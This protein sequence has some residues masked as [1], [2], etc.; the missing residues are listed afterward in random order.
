[1]AMIRFAH[2]PGQ[3]QPGRRGAGFPAVPVPVLCLALLAP[4]HARPAT[5]EDFLR[6]PLY[7]DITL[8]PSG[9]YL[10]VTHRQEDAQALSTFRLPGLKPVSSTR[11]HKDEGLA[12]VIWASEKR[13]LLQPTRRWQRRGRVQVRTGE[14][15][16]IDVN[17]RNLTL[18]WSYRVSPYRETGPA[19]R[20]RSRTT[21]PSTWVRILD[22]L[23]RDPRR[24][25][26]QT[27]GYGPEGIL[28]QALRMDIH[29]GATR[30]LHRSPVRN[31]RFVVDI[32]HRIGLVAGEDLSGEYQVW[33]RE[34]DGP[35]RLVHRSPQMEGG[36]TPLMAWKRPG[37]YLFSDT[38]SHPTSALLAWN[39]VSGERQEIFRHPQVSYGRIY[40]APHPRVWAIRYVDH[41]PGYHYPDPDHPFVALHKSLL[42]TFPEHDVTIVDQTRDLS[43]AVALVSG[44]RKPGTFLLMDVKKRTVL[45]TFES[46][47]WLEE[48]ALADME[49]LEITARDG[50][51]IRGYLT[52][53]PGTG[54]FPLVVMVHGGPYG[55]YDT[56]EFDPDVQLLASRGYAVAQVNYRGSGGRG[57]AFRAAG[58]R[59][60]GAAMQDDI[61]DTVRFLVSDGVADPQR[62]CIF[63]AS[64]G[65]YAALTGAFRDP[66]L[67]RCAVGVAGVYDLP[68]MLEKGDVQAYRAGLNFLET[69]LGTDTA[70][71]EAR[72]PAYNAERIRAAVMLIHGKRDERAPFAQALRMRKALT[73]AGNPPRWLVESHEAHGFQ[74]LESR[75]AMYRELLAFLDEHIGRRQ[76]A[77]GKQEQAQVFP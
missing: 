26:V 52:L 11:F 25:L 8:S 58:Y 71:L 65:A 67:Y 61:T 74:L 73:E 12:R 69:V 77:T 2:R 49:P 45:Q 21:D 66:D 37:W 72:S 55:I 57:Q 62:M 46:R 32:D 68:M 9:T 3:P 51:V 4:L 38:R 1:M 16:A 47:P 40:T 31:G 30:P 44:P 59:E 64:Y 48:A 10:A 27:G 24:I 36:L 33:A 20:A 54:P 13:L 19:R 18:L 53:P 29:N 70:D 43:L 7:D 50:L 76:D 75:V 56:W 28:N 5:V 39:P 17:G 35:F 60:W 15:A 63:G 34:P 22:L 23:P 14:L 42:A 41:F 6:D